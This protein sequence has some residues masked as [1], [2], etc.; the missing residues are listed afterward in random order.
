[1]DTFSDRL[2]MLGVRTT[3]QK[4]AAG[5]DRSASIADGVLYVL[6]CDLHIA[7]V[8]SSEHQDRFALERRT[9]TAERLPPLIE[10]AVRQ[11]TA[12]WSCGSSNAPGVAYP[13]PFLVVRTQPL[14]SPEGLFIGVRIERFQS[15]NSLSGAA[16]R[17]RI[18]PR[19]VQVLALLLDGNHLD[20]IGRRLFI[21]SSTVQDHIRS[22]FEKTGSGNRSEL[23]GRVL[24]WESASAE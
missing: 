18:S 11:L 12:T 22:L 8:W 21:T 16:S 5:I 1:L 3:S 24:G 15:A 20:Q 23:L 17:F 7:L 2:S 19:E 4:F 10:D 9:Q 14:T 13:V 6:D